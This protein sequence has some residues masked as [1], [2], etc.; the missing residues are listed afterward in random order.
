MSAAYLLKVCGAFVL[1]RIMPSLATTTKPMRSQAQWRWAWA[2]GQPFAKRWSHATPGGKVKRFRKLP[3]HV[4]KKEGQA[5]LVTLLK[6]NYGA[7]RG[8]VIAGRLV[9]GTGGRFASSGGAPTSAGDKLNAARDAALRKKPGG[10]KPTPKGR[11][12]RKP[13]KTDAQRAAEREA[14]RQQREQERAQKREQNIASAFSAIDLPEDAADSLRR[15]AAG[16]AVDDD[17]GLVKM[18]LAEQAKDGSYRLTA[19]GRVVMNAAERGD[20]GAARDAKSRATDRVRAEEEKRAAAEAKKPAGGG[21]GGK[22]KEPPKAGVRQ[23]SRLPKP[24]GGGGGGS[25]NRTQ[26][27]RQEA[28]QTDSA[29]VGL[30]QRLSQGDR[31]TDEESQTLIRNGLARV[32]KSGLIL[33]ATGARAIRTKEAPL[34]RLLVKRQHANHQQDS[35]NKQTNQ[36]VNQSIKDKAAQES[37]HTA[38]LPPSFTV[39]K[40]AE[41]PLRWIARSTTAYRDRDK[42]ILPTAVLD[43]DSQRMTRTKAY[44]PLRWWHVGRPD[45]TSIDAP[46]G[47]G[48]DL[49]TCDFS[50]QIGR[51][52]VESGTFKDAAIAA[53]IAATAHTYELSPGF[54]HAADQPDGEG[55]FGAIHTFERS[56]VPVR[57]ARA[58]NLFTGLTTTKEHTMD[59]AEQERRY[60]AM[61]TELGLTTEQAAALA[62]GLVAT[63]KAAATTA[64]PA[65]GQPGVA[66]KSDEGA[67]AGFWNTLRQWAKDEQQVT[68]KTTATTP[69][70]VVTPPDPN[71]ALIAQIAELTSTLKAAMEP[72]AEEGEEVVEEEAAEEAPIEEEDSS[73]PP[74]AKT[75]ADLS[76][77]DFANLLGTVLSQTL[78]GAM[79]GISDKVAALDGEMKA[80]GYTRQKDDERATQIATLKAEQEKIGTQLKELLEDQPAIP[81]RRPSEDPSNVLNLKAVEGDTPPE[82]AFADIADHLFGRNNQQTAH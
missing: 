81:P 36:Q 56:L 50:M 82:F 34:V 42:E 13:A 80:M 15:L 32:T 58:S 45:A 25:N 38:I 76:V 68:T 77:E 48:L 54:F 7:K 52:R 39:Y 64:D 70:V 6:A 3:G 51:V 17:G 53:R 21:G 5:L 26:S 61:V 71:A 14:K 22:K 8:Q 20:V 41:G 63:D 24:I 57:Y 43:L 40:S 33:T 19:T 78:A 65:T 2:T 28:A 59:Q 31:L 49:G 47:P 44:G 37:I 67:P 75:I 4:K 18:G 11:P 16:E 55:I 29:L 73:D 10:K 46:W 12:T 35:N 72:V 60:K 9:R 69:D 79:G 62:T 30:A 66:F 1:P 23:T 74:S 27:P